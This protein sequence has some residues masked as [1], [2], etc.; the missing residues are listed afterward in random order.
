MDC[1]QAA[2][3]HLLLVDDDRALLAELKEVLEEE[4]FRVT[5]AGNG[6][7]ALAMLTAGGVPD[8][9]LLDLLMPVMDGWELMCRLEERD[10]LRG[11][12]VLV[13]SAAVHMARPRVGVRYIPKPLCMETLLAEIG[14]VIA[15]NP[16]AQA[17]QPAPPPT[18]TAPAADAAE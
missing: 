3:R 4:G 10:D 17:R 15:G 7:R 12:P 6:A 8:A 1:R 11:V 5:T 18:G 14:A 2:M 16:P 13:M 9:I